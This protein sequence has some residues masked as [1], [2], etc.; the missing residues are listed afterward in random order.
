MFITLAVAENYFWS[1]VAS[2][3]RHRFGSVGADMILN[4]K[5]RRCQRAP[6]LPGLIRE[7]QAVNI[8]PCSRVITNRV[9]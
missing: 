2:A 5:R 9:Q 1:A 7:L 6:N 8:S 3:A 4:P